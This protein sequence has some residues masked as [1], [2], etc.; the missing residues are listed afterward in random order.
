MDRNEVPS[1]FNFPMRQPPNPKT[2]RFRLSDHISRSCLLSR[3][4]HCS[5]S[6]LPG[7]TDERFHVLHGSYIFFH[8][9]ISLHRSGPA[10]QAGPT[11][12][13]KLAQILVLGQIGETLADV[14]G[15]DLLLLA[16]EFT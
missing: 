1:V 8:G 9:T 6:R 12:Q 15:V 14:G 10:R 16:G 13:N 5:R 7:G 11:S 2:R 3:S 4:R